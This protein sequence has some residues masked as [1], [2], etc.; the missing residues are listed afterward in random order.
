MLRNLKIWWER[1]RMGKLPR[2]A[3]KLLDTVVGKKHL[4]S[5]V[6]KDLSEINLDN[7]NVRPYRYRGDF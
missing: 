6:Y 7:T 4:K 5:E 2:T 1:R 3:M